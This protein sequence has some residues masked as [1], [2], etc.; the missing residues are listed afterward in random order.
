MRD[1]GEIGRGLASL[2]GLIAVLV[3]VPAALIALG[4]GPAS[5]VSSGRGILSGL[6]GPLTDSALLQAASLLC[7]LLWALFALAVVTELVRHVP[8]FRGHDVEVGPSFRV[9]GLQGL[10]RTLVLTSMLLVSP[11][12]MAGSSP[13]TP[14]PPLPEP[15]L[16]VAHG[17]RET[18][19]ATQ[20]EHGSVR[21]VVQRYDS[22]WRIAERHLGDGTRWREIRDEHGRSLVQVHQPGARTIF[23]GQVLLLPVD[24]QVLV[25][26]AASS[27]PPSLEALPARSAPAASSPAK[28]RP[29]AVEPSPPPRPVAATPAPPAD[30]VVATPGPAGP[31]ADT[32][33]PSPPPPAAPAVA[34]PAPTQVPA[35][36]PHHRA[37]S[38]SSPPVIFAVNSDHH[39]RQ[40]LPATLAEAGLLSAAVLVVVARLRRRQSRHRP[41]GRRIRLPGRHL[42]TVEQALRQ[43]ERP[44]LLAAVDHTLAAL[45][46]D[47]SRAG[48]ATPDVL[49][50][51]ACPGFVEVL[52]D[53]PALPPAGWTLSSEGF[54]WRTEAELPRAESDPGASAPL[55]ALVPLGRAAGGDAEVL[56][57]L[58]VA[59]VLGVAGDPLRAAGVVRAI[60][61]SLAGVPWG[62]ASNVM[63]VGFGE[64]LAALEHI[65]AVSSI[66]EV[67]AELVATAEVMGRAHPGQRRGLAP[68]IVLCVRPPSLEELRTLADVTGPGSTIVAVIPLGR[69]PARW[70]IDADADPMPVDPIRLALQPTIL[71]AADLED[72]GG[73]LEVA[74]DKGGG[75]LAE[76]PY[77]A[78]ELSI[79]GGEASLPTQPTAV[80]IRVLGTVE[81][82]GADEFRRAK[83]RELVVYL[84]MHPS[85]VGE[86]ELDEAMW[87]SDR[88][89]V[90]AAATRDSTVSVARTAL[91]GPTRLLPA[92]GQGREKRYQ[93]GPDVASDWAMFCALN[94]QARASG[95]V[96]P[97]RQ[98]LELVRGRP[99]EGAVSG[100]SYGWIHTEGHGRHI[101]A[102]VADAADLAAGMYLEEGRP[103]DA[104]WSARQGLTADPLAERLWVR[105]MQ[106]ADALG[107]SLEIERIMD[108][109]D[110][111]LELGGDFSG[112]H[113]NT[114]KAYDRL[115]RRRH[116]GHERTPRMHPN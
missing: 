7:W 3:G 50:V 76:E 73:L 55:P 22:P 44:D 12:D 99:F 5:V 81:V 71:S 27:H 43:G 35:P 66:D 82:E 111:I 80:F 39:G 38:D 102:E 4:G 10:A 19:P 17:A 72:I 41:P 95:Q 92:Q 83:S 103:L 20:A 67:A 75:T 36:P 87:P 25:S 21:Y 113:P 94:R 48:L 60:A 6:R 33:V 88:G 114:L 101:E 65:R 107:E 34:P 28:S 14:L 86:A 108:E 58:E 23:A 78:I 15:I 31:A 62:Q 79:D 30:P 109:M 96:D 24:A 53:R 42:A 16:V 51:V 45:A 104:R 100:R 89:R 115:S 105:L 64:E 116:G 26:P 8:R 74:R 98:A 97:L 110:V 13:G 29:P 59:R 46:A 1:R 47:I 9:P 93:L 69:A 70:V 54:R 56:I 52:I 49:G 61:T 90:V 77:D 85:G 68:T 18:R 106:A 2:L 57:N 40:S 37:D 84:S 63:V 112:L 32:A 11:R 91:G